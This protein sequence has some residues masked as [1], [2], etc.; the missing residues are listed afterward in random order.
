[1]FAKLHFKPHSNKVRPKA[2]GFDHLKNDSL[3]VLFYLNE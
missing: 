2:L 3:N 1:M